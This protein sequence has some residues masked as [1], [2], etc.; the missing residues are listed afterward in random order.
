M[1]FVTWLCIGG[2]HFLWERECNGEGGGGK[3]NIL[4]TPDKGVGG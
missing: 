2:S 1:D 3:V 4:K